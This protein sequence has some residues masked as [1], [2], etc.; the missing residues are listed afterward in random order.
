MPPHTEGPAPASPLYLSTLSPPA[1]RAATESVPIL[2]L[3]KPLA[4]LIYL[5][6]SPNR[7]AT[8]SQLASL[9][10]G[11]QQPESSRHSVRQ[12]IWYLR[13]R[14]NR[15]LVI[16]DGESLTLAPEIVVDRDEFLARAERGDY[17]AALQLYTEP[18]V[19]AFATPGGAGFEDWCALERRRLAEVYRHACEHVVREKLSA[20]R[21][22]EAVELA[23]T[24]RDQDVYDERGWRLLLEVALSAR[25]MLLAR[26]EAEALATLA[27]QEE[28]ELEPATRAAMRQSRGLA[29]K[30]EPDD[31]SDAAKGHGFAE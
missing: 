10:W 13:R 17:E 16:A 19:S 1:L 26:T 29:S 5:A 15:D 7:S 4:L 24:L 14:A 25:D 12:A 21:A 11:D 18:Y 9:L 27:Q 3:G 30:D 20:G 8:R 28:M 23:R 31:G 22:R 6:A 2:G